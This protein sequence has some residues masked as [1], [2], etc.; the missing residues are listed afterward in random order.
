MYYDRHSK[1]TGDNRDH[2]RADSVHPEDP[3]FVGGIAQK[4][5]FQECTS[6]VLEGTM[7]GDNRHNE[8]DV[9]Q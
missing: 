4:R 9:L 1:R 7:K 3:R 2:F 5:R 6:S 8:A